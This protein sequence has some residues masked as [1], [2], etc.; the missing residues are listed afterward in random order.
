MPL[1]NIQGENVSHEFLFSFL[2]SFSV[3]SISSDSLIVVTLDF[4]FSILVIYLPG[5]STH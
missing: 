4:L 2:I 5:I 3:M 1:T